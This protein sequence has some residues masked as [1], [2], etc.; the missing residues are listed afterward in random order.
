MRKNLHIQKRSWL[1]SAVS[2][3]FV[4]VSVVA[5]GFILL[6]GTLLWGG[7]KIITDTQDPF[8]GFAGHFPLFVEKDEEDGHTVLVT[9]A[10]KRRYFNVQRFPKEKEEG[11][12]RIFCM[13]GS[14]TFGRP[15]DDTTSF[16]GWLRAMLPKIDPSHRWEVINVGGISYATYRV[17]TLM[18]EMTAYDPDLFLLYTGQNE[19]LEARTY[20][21][22]KEKP[23]WLQAMRAAAMMTRTFAV[24]HRL[25]NTQ[26]Q[27]GITSP[28]A[29]T[30]LPA[31]VK[32]ILDTSVGPAA[33]HRDDEHRARVIAHTRS[34]LARMISMGRSVGAE[35]MFITPASN[36][37]DCA[38]FKSEHSAG[39]GDEARATIVSQMA[40]ASEAYDVGDFYA[41]LAAYDEALKIDSRYARLHY[42]RGRVLSALDRHD[43]AR[44]AF[45]RARDEDVCPLRAPTEIAEMIREVAKQ[46]ETPLIDFETMIAAKVFPE[47]P[48]AESFV[49]HVH[50]TIEGHRQLALEILAMMEKRG[51]VQRAPTWD[52]RAEVVVKEAVEA[53]VDTHA[54]SRALRTISKVYGW[55]GKFEEA[56][57]IAMRASAIDEMNP[58]VWYDVALSALNFA[59]NEEAVQHFEHAIALNPDY[60]R[61]HNDLGNVLSSLAH[62]E[63]A[64]NRF[65][66]AV[67]LKPNSPL[68]HNNLANELVAQGEREEGLLH[69]RLA[70]QADPMHTISHSNLGVALLDRGDYAEAVEHLETAV[71]LE[72]DV[73]TSRYN[74]A[75]ALLK[76]EDLHGA[77]T[78][79]QHVYEEMKNY[80]PLQYHLGVA[81]AHIGR[82]DEGV[83]HLR[84]ALTLQPT[85]AEA[86]RTLAQLLPADRN[87]P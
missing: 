14:T 77:I 74:L 66:H 8:V 40:W 1:R 20:A 10:N 6:E 47:V 80:A 81:L 56:H 82:V 49:D 9:A 17:A 46:F 4:S 22:L 13:G 61:A 36:L 41:A 48:G 55:A 7:G 31:E 21:T 42:E 18:E 25:S 67:S 62:T 38:P 11:T 27:V 5:V 69:Y 59:R 84:Q 53:A 76:S 28:D 39:I 33:Y 3:G 64:L 78:H 75:L 57:R 24:V 65:R 54:H 51:I 72:P 58:E 45:V 63:R 37:K 34:N 23:T 60:A 15:Y 30:L 86:S 35:V 26:K 70:L 16:C 68:Y 87:I 85:Y 43:E 44:Y 73:A 50:P 2:T 29:G 71:R 83:L 32:A 19:F 52:A 79:F 12:Y